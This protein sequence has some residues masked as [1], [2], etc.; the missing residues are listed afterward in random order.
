MRQ[1]NHISL[2]KDTYQFC[3]ISENSCTTWP[4]NLEAESL[5]V[6]QLCCHYSSCSRLQ[7]QVVRCESGPCPSGTAKGLEIIILEIILTFKSLLVTWCTNSLTFNNCTFCP[8]CIYVFCIYL[9]TNSDLCHLQ[10]KRIGFYNR[11]GKCLLRGTNWV[12]N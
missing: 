7:E 8:H 6:T 12:F 5:P 10:R 11:G 4:P 2:K 9:R 1:N 3:R